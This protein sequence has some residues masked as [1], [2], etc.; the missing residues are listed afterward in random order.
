[1]NV[2]KLLE[3]DH[4]Q[5]SQLFER[6]LKTSNDSTGKR[7]ELFGEL[8][9]EL[10]A[11][12]EAEEKVFYPALK[13]P[14]QTHDLTLEA[15]EEHHV[16]KQLL[17]ELEDMS[18]NSDQWIAKLTVLQENVEH[19]VEEEENHLFPKARQVLSDAQANEMGRK[20]KQEKEKHLKAS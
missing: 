8:K 3:K 20:I 9:S 2:Y 11:H 5:A 6:L 16:V 14:D 17:K 12:S 19:H 18:K 15:I 10:M 13:N 7:E 4:K 1:M